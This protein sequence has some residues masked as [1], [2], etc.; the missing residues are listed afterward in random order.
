M[1]EST[2]HAV[3][4]TA[5]GNSYQVKRTVATG[6]PEN[7]VDT[8]RA[9]TTSAAKALEKLAEPIE[10][11]VQSVG[12]DIKL[13]V[14]HDTGVIQAEVRDPSG[15]KVIRKLPSDEM[16]KLAASIR[17]FSEHMVDRSL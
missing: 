7:G 5:Y 14:D 11:F 1:N 2:I 15:E 17:E 4:T 13:N 3:K 12:V 6:K 9:E 10:K 8:S 16:L